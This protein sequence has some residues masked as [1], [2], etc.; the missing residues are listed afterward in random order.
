MISNDEVTAFDPRTSSEEVRQKLREKARTNT[1]FMAKAVVG[2]KDLVPSVHGAM[3]KF[4]DGPETRKLALAPRDHLK[5]SVWTIANTLVRIVRNPNIR[6]LLG[7]ETATNASHFLR[8]IQAVFERNHV[9]R[10]LFPELIP[11]FNARGTKWSETEMCVNRTE[12]YPE[13]TVEAI[14]VGGAVVSRHY[15]LIKLDDLVGK[16]AS[17]SEQVMNKTIDWYIYVESLLDDPV[18]SEIQNYGT[19]WGYHDLHSWARDHEEGAVM[20]F[21][22]CYIE[23][24]S[25]WWPERFPPEALQRLRRKLG[26][27]KFSCQYLNEPKDPDT[28]SFDVRWLKFFELSGYKCRFDG[29]DSVDWRGMH[30]TLRLDPAISDDDQACDSAI[31]VDGVDKFNR[32]FLLHTWNGHV[33]PNEMLEK[34]FE[35]ADTWTV[36]AIGVESVAFQKIL[37]FLFEQHMQKLGVDYPIVEL[38]PDTKKSKKARIRGIQPVFERGEVYVQKTQDAFI[39]QYEE[40]PTGRLIDV[41]DA[42]AYGPQMWELPETDIDETREET[43]AYNRMEFFEGRSEVTG[44]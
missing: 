5:T 9:F 8:R 41:L 38:R 21:R 39:Q 42:F 24:G 16:E 20:F 40:F 3:C 33:Q 14:G 19:R 34:V 23:D 4:I 11:D 2:F 18:R 7:N 12:D 25:P 17:E 22:S 1:Y 26:S 37:K 29:S 13:A 32:K 28:N 36:D 6:I 30:R 27:F 43:R 35:L 44:Y 15:N 31:V 10:W